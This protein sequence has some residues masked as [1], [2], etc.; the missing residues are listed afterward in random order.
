M[1]GYKEDVEIILTESFDVLTLKQRTKNWFI[2]R[3][4]RLTAFDATV[5][6][7]NNSITRQAM[8]MPPLVPDLVLIEQ[9]ISNLVKIWFSRKRS[10][11]EMLRRSR[12]EIA[13][14]PGLYK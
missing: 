11:E 10:T 5:F 2:F 9:K 4:M 14:L 6:L 12:N 8:S 7:K 13:A 1:K 3:K